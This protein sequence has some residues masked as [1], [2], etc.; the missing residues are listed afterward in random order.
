MVTNTLNIS[1]YSDALGIDS[2]YCRL[3]L[4]EKD[5]PVNIIE[6][7]AN[8][9]PED[10][11]HLSP[12]QRVPL[13]IDRDV[14]L[15]ETRII[16]EYL[17]ERFPHPTLLPTHPAPR[18]SSRLLCY[19]IF[20]DWIAIAENIMNTDDKTIKANQARLLADGLTS[21]TAV[22]A[23]RPFFLSDSYS[24][25]DC[26]LSVLLWRLPTLGV[27]LPV[28]AKPIIKYAQRMFA[29]EG[30]ALGL[31]AQEKRLSQLQSWSNI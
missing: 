4:A 24:L 2:H 29:R 30:F 1:L 23:D 5:V 12:Y 22:F 8:A 7:N 15:Y 16:S 6:V 9:L 10:V 17:E 18:A 28:Q 20:H 14:V 26:A 13:L 27:I 25:A 21:V 31:S 19:R 3:I 11:L